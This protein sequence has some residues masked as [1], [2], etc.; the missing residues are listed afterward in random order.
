MRKIFIMLLI[1]TSVGIMLADQYAYTEDGKKVLLKSDGTWEYV[2]ERVDSSSPAP[3]Q[4]LEIRIE[5]DPYGISK[6]LYVIVKNVSNKTIR[7]YKLKVNFYDDFGDKVD[8]LYKYYVAQELNLRPNQ[9]NGKY[10]YWTIYQ[11]TVTKAV[12]R[13]VEVVFTDGSRWEATK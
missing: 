6:R 7:A 9:I 12:P 8:T 10:S 5:N 1:L 13:V 3:L 4:I 11:S 2:K